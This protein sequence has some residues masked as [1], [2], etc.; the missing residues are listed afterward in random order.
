MNNHNQNISMLEEEG[1]VCVRNAISLDI[2]EEW[3]TKYTNAWNEIKKH[4]N[5]LDWKTMKYKRE[6]LEHL[7][8]NKKE[9]H[10]QNKVYD[11]DF[12]GIDLY[13][14]KKIAR[15]KDTD[16]YDM[17]NGRYDFVFGLE[18]INP[19]ISI[20]ISEIIKSHL[21]F[22]YSAYVGGLPV[23]KQDDIN[24]THNGKWHR[25]CYSL[26]NNEMLDLML[27]PMYLTI[28]IP[29]EDMDTT[30]DDNIIR[31][32]FIKGSHKMNLSEL[33][34]RN[35]ETLETWIQSR[36]ELLV[37]PIL[38]A[39]DVCIFNGF[40]IHRG[41]GRNVNNDKDRCMLYVVCKKIWL[42]DEPE[43]NYDD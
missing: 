31:T 27:P 42:N 25:D 8:F 41:A 21:K 39:G 13:E 40:T 14:G 4:W 7:N 28:L 20:E 17:G 19:F 32:E 12:I 34:I 1:L 29:L 18:T 15:F 10:I 9:E 38:K 36:N 30:D 2:I 16:I 5:T 37:S 23:E 6:H 3:K 26:F 24:E 22:A 11:L 35:K 43:D 33:D